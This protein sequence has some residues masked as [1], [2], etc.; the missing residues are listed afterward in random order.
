[1]EFSFLKHK[2]ALGSL[3]VSRFPLS[4]LLAVQ[5]SSKYRLLRHLRLAATPGMGMT[6]GPYS[7]IWKCLSQAVALLPSLPSAVCLG[8]RSAATKVLW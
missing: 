2:P 8:Q 6:T 7:G 1:M 3:Y 4:G 5:S